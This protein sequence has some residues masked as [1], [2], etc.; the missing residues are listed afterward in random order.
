MIKTDFS[1]ES[2]YSENKQRLARLKERYRD[3][4]KCANWPTGICCTNESFDGQYEDFSEEESDSHNSA[5]EFIFL[6]QRSS[7]MQD[8]KQRQV[9]FIFEEERK[10]S[11]VSMI[12]VEANGPSDDLCN[13]NTPQNF[14][15]SKFRKASV[16]DIMMVRKPL[17]SSQFKNRSRRVS[18]LR[19]K[20]KNSNSGDE[21][22]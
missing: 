18:L 21:G 5:D 19:D 1:K 7:P 22:S 3:R 16:P 10:V 6:S 20:D 13:P 11:T 15:K 12:H 2:K 4:D 8:Q 17:I 9:K 14:P